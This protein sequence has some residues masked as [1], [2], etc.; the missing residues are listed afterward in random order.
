MQEAA[1]RYQSE[2]L[3][4]IYIM[5]TGTNTQKFT[6]LLES[7]FGDVDIDDLDLQQLETKPI[8]A[9]H[10]EASQAEEAS[11]SKEHGPILKD[12]VTHITVTT[13]PVPIKHGIPELSIPESKNVK[14]PSATNPAK[15]LTQ[16]YY[17]CKHCTKLSQNKVSMM[18]H[19][20]CC[21][22]IKLICGGCNKEY[23]SMV[24][25]E[26]HISEIHGGDVEMA[27]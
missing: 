23:D 5:C 9:M 1:A 22:N 20:R 6:D 4:Q 11:M 15:K 24:S 19:T 12:K 3:G 18:N 8:Q 2:G 10:E 27:Q 13:T 16:F 7:M 25:I 26:K 14:Y 21:L 17:N